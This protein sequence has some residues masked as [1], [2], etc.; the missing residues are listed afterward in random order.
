MDDFEY[1]FNSYVQDMMLPDVSREIAAAQRDENAGNFLSALGLLCYT[2]VMGRWVPNVQRGSRNAF[3]TFFKRLGP[4][5][6][7]F[8]ASGE[9]PYDF[10][11]NGMAHTYITKGSAVISM[12]EGQQ[13]PAPCGVFKDT[14][15]YYHLVV[16]RYFRDFVVACARLY[17]ERLGH[18][19]HLIHIWAPDLFPYAGG[20]K[21]TNADL[22]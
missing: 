9:N 19:H 10:Y 21:T 2:E 7:Q 1:F 14:Y 16:Q 13:H 17:K 3:D 11:R 20:L 8:I 6:E 15:G 22:A 5:Y 12:L 18:R 4:C